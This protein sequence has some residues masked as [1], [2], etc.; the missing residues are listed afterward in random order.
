MQKNNHLMPVCGI[1]KVV[2]GL[3]KQPFKPGVDFLYEEVVERH[4]PQLFA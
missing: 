1:R 3:C 4:C 2:F